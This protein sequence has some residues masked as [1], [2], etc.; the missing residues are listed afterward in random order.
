MR[1]DGSGNFHDVFDYI[2]IAD[3]HARRAHDQVG[4]GVQRALQMGLY[5][6]HRILRDTKPDLPS[7]FRDVTR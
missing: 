4:A 5:I 6:F 1:N 3:G 7:Y 2:V